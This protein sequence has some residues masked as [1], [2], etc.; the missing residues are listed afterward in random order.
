MW[1]KMLNSETTFAMFLERVNMNTNEQTVVMY[2]IVLHLF[3]I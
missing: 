2:A 1:C 3:Q